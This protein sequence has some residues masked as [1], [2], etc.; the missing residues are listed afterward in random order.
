MRT[1]DAAPARK[2]LLRLALVV[3]IGVG[4]FVVFQFDPSRTAFYPPCGFHEL[5][6]LWCPGCGSTRALHQI[7]HGNL[8]RAIGFN[9]AVVLA[10]PFL[11]LTGLAYLSGRELHAWVPSILR[12]PWMV[13][14]LALAIGL[15]G[16]LRNV[17][18][19]PFSWL[20][21]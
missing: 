7:S 3:G 4:A 11:T 13:W 5:T 12:R 17:P 19:E 1:V 2:S 21:P 8:A 14:A 10:L 6:G 18:A 20:A 16:I 9:L 15:F